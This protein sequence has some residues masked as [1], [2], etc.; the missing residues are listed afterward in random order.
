MPNC[1]DLH[2]VHGFSLAI[3]K[4]TPTL[5]EKP[6]LRWRVHLAHHRPAE[7][8][9]T[10]G[11]LSPRCSPKATNMKTR[12]MLVVVASVGVAMATDTC[13]Q[14]SSASVSRQG[15]FGERTVGG[16]VPPRSRTWA[17]GSGSQG[18]RDRATKAVPTGVYQGRNLLEAVG[19]YSRRVQGE[20]RSQWGNW[21]TQTRG[22]PRNLGSPA[23]AV[24]RDAL[25]PAE[26]LSPALLPPPG[27]TSGEMSVRESPST[28]SALARSKGPSRVP[29]APSSVDES[30]PGQNGASQPER[31][32]ANLTS[33]LGKALRS[34]ESDLRV[35]LRGTVAVLRGSVANAAQRRLAERFVGL[36]PGVS[37]VLN[38]L[39]TS[40]P[41]QQDGARPPVR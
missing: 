37:Q 25:A 5:P 3:R 17:F 36:E 8:D 28:P 14:S 16:S 20:Y 29:V 15:I 39:V 22:R 23:D 33:R 24:P 18:L 40:G 6:V 32:D 35:S 10:K 27:E 19:Q 31:F 12:V 26:L 2:A 9:T 41:G 7:Y 4:Q 38:E 13:A 1:H 11:S 34:P 21:N 30:T